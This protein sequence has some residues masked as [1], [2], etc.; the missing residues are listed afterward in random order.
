M[1]GSESFW[2]YKFQVYATGRLVLGA[3]CLP[4]GEVILADV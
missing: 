3:H 2:V 4:T 1:F